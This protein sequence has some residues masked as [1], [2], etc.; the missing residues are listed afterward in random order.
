[1]ASTGTRLLAIC[2]LALTTAAT[3]APVVHDSIPDFTV[4]VGLQ[5]MSRNATDDGLVNVALPRSLLNNMFDGDPTTVY[6][7]GLGGTGAGGELELLIAPTTNPISSG[8][9]VTPGGLNG[10]TG[11]ID[12]SE[13][14]LGID[15]GNYQLV[16]R[17]GSDGSIDTV[18]GLPNVLLTA[19]L[20]D[21]TTTFSL[22][23][24]SG[25]YNTVQFRDVT[26]NEGANRDGFDV[27]SLS[28]V[29][30]AAVPTPG[31][32]AIVALGLAG[33]SLVRRRAG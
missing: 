11:A 25:T 14:Y 9:L 19:T 28:L 4:I 31:T 3:A 22:S 15:G 5:G 13:L 16:G 6:S 10:L 29:S 20:A 1:M 32:L 23:V 27:G 8:T 33:L 7:L 12:F 21:D 17:L 18:G 26:P 30:G 24:L 2:A